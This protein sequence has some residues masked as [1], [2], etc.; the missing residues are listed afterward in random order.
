MNNLDSFINK[1]KTKCSNCKEYFDLSE[2][3]PYHVGKNLLDFCCNCVLSHIP[4]GHFD[5]YFTSGEKIDD[6]ASKNLFSKK[7]YVEN[8]FYDHCLSWNR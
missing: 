1:D 5:S 7:Y 6:W 2:I 4:F 3:Y 8:N